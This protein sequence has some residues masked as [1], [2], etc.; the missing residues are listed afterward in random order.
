MRD[1]WRTAPARRVNAGQHLRFFGLRPG[2]CPGLCRGLGATVSIAGAR[3][4]RLPRVNSVP[5]IRTR[6][7]ELRVARLPL[8]EILL[9]L[10]VMAGCLLTGL[11]AFGLV[12]PDDPRYAFIARAMLQS[13]DWVTPRLYGH[14][15][16]EKPVLHYWTAAAAFRLF[17]VTEF[18]ARLPS[19]LAAVL[20][21]LAIAW[22]ARR[23][24]GPY[25]AQLCLLMMP[26]TIAAIAFARAATPD[27]LF[28]AL[29]AAAAVAAA[30][31]LEKTNATNSARIAFGAFLGAATLAKGPA[32]V[33]LAAGAIALWALT[34]R[35]WR[36]SLRLLHPLGVASFFAVASPWYVLCAVRN[37]EFLR[38]FILEHNFERYLTPVFQHPQPFWFFGVI[39]PAAVL[40]WTALFIPVAISAASMR[41][42]DGWRHSAA[43]FFAC[44][45]VFSVLFFSF[46]QSK[47]P[48]YILP[49]VPPLV[50]V[51]AAGADRFLGAATGITAN[52]HA[53]MQARWW[54]A[55]VGAPFVILPPIAGYWLRNLPVESGFL[56]PR[57]MPGLLALSVSGG[58]LCALVALFGGA[59]RALL[60]AAVLMTAMV[61]AINVRVLPKLDPY[62]S[63]RHAAREMPPEARQAADLS[64]FQLERS[65]QYGFNFYLD[66]D[67]PAWAPG[68]APP[69]W[70]WTSAA[71]AASLERLG[72]QYG[73]TQRVSSQAWLLRLH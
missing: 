8:W 6:S 36:A 47:L 51:F 42:G 64:V 70:M 37:P 67:L 32:A 62:F 31:M 5:P 34:S 71:G 24:Y 49:A 35:A 21:T 19:A 57:G 50:F 41:L 1:G 26:S 28:A 68:T 16:F 45:A 7:L 2:L 60:L 54:V 63:P 61:I 65:W 14:P 13:G 10:A 4:V 33:I 55:L 52:E 3:N 23:A 20:A 43:L 58:V 22:A 9:A 12:G 66:R 17:G 29:L 27:M 11:G 72:I 44:W 53:T 40:P 18:A 15:W 73:V 48:G 46:S 38:I 39:I 56:S 69:S 25:A 59:R 30:A